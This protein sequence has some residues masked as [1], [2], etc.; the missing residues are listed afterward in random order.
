MP[1]GDG[2]IA[3]LFT[4]IAAVVILLMMVN[5]GEDE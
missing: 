4:I 5:D 3:V 2:M 1:E